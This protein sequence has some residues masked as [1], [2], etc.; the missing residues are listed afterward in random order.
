MRRELAI[1]LRARVTWAI[2]A[3]SALLVG[4]G[5]VLAVDLFSASSRSTFANALQ[6]REMDP[7]AGVVRPTLGGLDLALVLLGPLIAARPLAIEKERGTFGALC[8][9]E[10][11]SFRVIAKKTLSALSA[12]GL[13]FVAPVVLLVAFRLAGGHV[14][15]LESGVALGGSFLR[16]LLIVSVSVAAAAWVPTFAQAVSFGIAVSLSSWAIDAADGFAALSWLG[17]ASAWSVERK[18]LPSQKGII[19][20]GSSLWLLSAAAI[21]FGL[22]CLGGSFEPSLRRK[23]GLGVSIL[24]AGTVALS[25][26]ASVRRAYDWTEGRRASLPPAVV[27]GLR[28]IEGPIELDLYLDRDDSRRRQLES[29][30]LEKLTLARSDVAVRMPLDQSAEVVEA[31]RDTGYGRI[32]IR[33]GGG[34]RATRST[35]RREI[36]T[37]VFEAAGRPLP[38]WNQPVYPGFPVVMEGLRRRCLLGLAYAAI[39][40]SLLALG[41]HFS[42]RRTAR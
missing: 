36:T 29:D 24:I 33:A 8:L 32:V 34:T 27:E 19:A 2:A 39:P 38:D 12:C 40:L 17:G 15:F 5:F 35:S 11:S 18:L 28:E 9:A 10:G 6:A 41:L 1:A 16:M 23:L 13:S 7:L 37:L 22:A 30:V 4:H 42:R 26:L 20:V 14:D 3:L 31:P 21:A 25:A